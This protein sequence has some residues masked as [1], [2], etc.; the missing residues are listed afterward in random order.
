MSRRKRTKAIVI[1]SFCLLVAG[2]AFM[3]PE[4]VSRFTYKIVATEA[5][6]AREELTAIEDLSTAFKKVAKSM[7]PSVV[8]IST[9]KRVQTGFQ[10]Q[11]R[12]L[13]PFFRSPFD[14][15]FGDDFFE[16][17]FGGRTPENFEQRGLGTG[18]IVNDDGYILTNNHVVAEANEVTV[19]LIDE[20][21]PI[22]CTRH[23]PA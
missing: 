10:R 19:K 17:F 3:V 20:P 8:N 11:P 21:A 13:D 16:R 1:L 22:F 4:L 15:F 5:L 9:V 7:R 23:A 2:T 12:N 6:A 18:V 14:D